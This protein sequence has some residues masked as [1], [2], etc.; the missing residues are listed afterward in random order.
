MASHELLSGPQDHVEYAY[1]TA[2]RKVINQC[3]VK[4]KEDRASLK[5]FF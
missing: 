3:F 5:C 1:Q 2:C 4:L